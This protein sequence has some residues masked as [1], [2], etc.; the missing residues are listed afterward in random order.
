MAPRLKI[1][2]K[3]FGRVLVL[4]E[5][6]EHPKQGSHWM[7]R[8]DCGVEKIIDGKSLSSGNTK[9]CGCWKVD[10]T[11][12]RIHGLSKSRIYDLWTQMIVRCSNPNN[13][14]YYRYGG[15]GI[16]VCSRWSDGEHGKT[17][18]ECFIDDMGEKPRGKSLDRINVDGDYEPANCRWATNTQQCRNKTNNARVEYDGRTYTWSELSEK[19]VVSAQLIRSRVVQ[20]GWDLKDAMFTPPK[21][22]TPAEAGAECS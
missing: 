6:P 3:R 19:G 18:F 11:C 20:Y 22:K 17:G 7:C 16:K 9:S 1:E 13:K 4:A 2:G 15:R 10:G 8:C 12:R 21:R 5:V 14:A